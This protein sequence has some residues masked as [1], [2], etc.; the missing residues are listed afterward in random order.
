MCNLTDHFNEEEF[1]KQLEQDDDFKA[2]M[3]QKRLEWIEFMEHELKSIEDLVEK[4]ID[5]YE[6]THLIP[7][8]E[9]Q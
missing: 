4:E 7:T 2:Y 3:E 8:E 5:P 6:H 9:N 1:Y